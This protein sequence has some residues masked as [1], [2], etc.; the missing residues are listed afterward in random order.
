MLRDEGRFGPKVVPGRCACHTVGVA[1][2]VAWEGCR[3][4]RVLD[5]EGMLFLRAFFKEGVNQ[6]NLVI[7]S[8]SGVHGTYGTIEDARREMK[9]PGVLPVV[10]F[11]VIKPRVVQMLYGNALPRSVDDLDF[12]SELRQ[13]S[14]RVLAATGA[15]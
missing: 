5:E 2:G 6:D 13:Q 10:T 9:K 3:V 7:F 12:L 11:L 1:A 4:Q 15:P 8:T 14:W